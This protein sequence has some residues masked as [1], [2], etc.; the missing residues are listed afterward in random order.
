[1][2]K[3]LRLLSEVVLRTVKRRLTS[4]FAIFFDKKNGGER[5]IRTLGE[6]APTAIF[7]TAAL[8]HSAISP[9]CVLYNI[10]PDCRFDNFF[11]EEFIRLSFSDVLHPVRQIQ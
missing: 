5:G 7:E 9:V 6:V 10:A 1:M 2:K 8:D 4:S 11:I 3:R